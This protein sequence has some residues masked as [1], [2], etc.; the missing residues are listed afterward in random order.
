MSRLPSAAPEDVVAVEAAQHRR[1]VVVHGLDVEEGLG[2]REGHVRHAELLALVDVGR[3]AVQVQHGGQ[4]PWPTR[5]G[6]DRRRR[7]G[8]RPRLVVVVPVEAV[9]PVSARPACQ[10][11]S[12]ALRS[13]SLQRAAVPLVR[14]VVEPDVLELEHHVDLPALRVGEEPRF[15]HRH[16][17][18]LPDGQ[19]PVLAA[20]EHLAVHL[21]E[22]LVDA[23]AAEVVR[24]AVAVEPAVSQVAVRQRGVLG[25]HVDD[26]HPE[27]VDAAVEPPAHHRVDGLADLGVLPVEVGLLAGEQVQ[28]VLAGRLVELPRRAAERRLP[29]GRLGPVRA[30]LHPF[31]R[32]APPV[33]VP[34]G[35]SFDE[36]DSTNHGCSSEVWLTTRSMTIRMPR[37]WACSRSSSK[38]SRVPNVGSMSW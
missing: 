9:P 22:E 4:E 33:P 21:L 14:A 6:S 35:E 28:V 7:S 11:P 13:T 20:L 2:A 34:L 1:V 19:E 10:R 3:A 31:A 38:S 18:H 15:P 8:D 16:P 36:R 32:R 30:R 17:G 26:V 12:E 5:P 25:D 29:V 27:A 24:A 23:R 37:A